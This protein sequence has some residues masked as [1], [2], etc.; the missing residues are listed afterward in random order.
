MSQSWTLP[1]LVFLKAGLNYDFIFEQHLTQI[2]FDFAQDPKLACFLKDLAALGSGTEGLVYFRKRILD[3]F[4][5]S[6]N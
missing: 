2:L 6:C 4:S 5:I 3:E 1:I